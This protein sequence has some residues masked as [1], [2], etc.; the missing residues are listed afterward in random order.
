MK[1]WIQVLLL[2]AVAYY[3]Y[4]QSDVLDLV[5][6]DSKGTSAGELPAQVMKGLELTEYKANAHGQ[7]DWKL[8]AES[9]ASE[10]RDIQWKVNKA[11]VFLYKENVELVQITSEQGLVDTKS[12]NLKLTGEVKSTME[13]GYIFRSQGLQ[14]HASEETF[15][16]EGEIYIEGPEKR[17]ILKGSSFV[18]DL[19][20][21]FVNINGP[22]YCEQI[23]PEFDKAIIKSKEAQ[24][25]I[26]SR[27]VLFRGQLFIQ[28]DEMN[29]SGH[30][31]EFKYSKLT[32]ELES[33]VIRG[34][35][36]ASQGDKSA[37]ADLLEIRVKDGVFLFQGNPRFVSGENTLVGNEI[38]LYNKGK[39][40]QVLHG[41][42]KTE[43]NLDLIKDQ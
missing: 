12:K 6:Q 8:Q 42:V 36:F 18:G 15:L 37:S 16:S 32:G 33:L 24:V 1:F 25:N 29:V 5:T 21:G 22:V 39:N 13:S 20:Q 40:V 19:K 9:A 17:T 28:L 41:R 43:P 35:V 31:A 23:I 26:E 2:C 4:H 7:K 3:F 34:K 38:L 14:Y 10:L 30:E 27:H 11:F